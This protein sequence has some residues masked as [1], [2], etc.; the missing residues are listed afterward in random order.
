MLNNLQHMPSSNRILIYVL[1]MVV[2]IVA[3]SIICNNRGDAWEEKVR[4]VLY[5]LKNDSVPSYATEFIDEKGIPY[6]SYAPENGIAAGT[7]YNATIVANYALSYYEQY[8]KKNDTVALNRF[9]HC[10]Q[11]LLNEMQ[12]M[13]NA[14]LFIFNWQQP[15]YPAVKNPFTSGMTSGRAINAFMLA[16]KYSGDSIYLKQSQKLLRGYYIPIEKGGFTYITKNGWW[17]EEVADTNGQT[18]K[19]LDGHIYA[20]QGVQHLWQF[21][22][23]DS[24]QQVIQ[25]GI[26]ALIQALPLY[27]GDHGILYY[28][29]YQ[30]KAD[31]KYRK[32]LT[33][34]MQELWE[35]TNN[36]VFLN[37]Y[38]KWSKPLK[39]LYIKRIFAEKNISGIVLF[40]LVTSLL[41]GAIQLLMKL[42]SRRSS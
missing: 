8:Q 12:P 30:K 40:S 13:E 19:I 28:D 18:P 10:I 5:Q 25:R 37:Y 1:Q 15:W 11:W 32:I 6:V 26:D 3:A 34:Q 17:Y 41:F 29:V 21:T 27:D 23:D 14:A 36:P 35:T 31:K 7:K 22:K 38:N 33:Q 16:F 39:Q 9:N 4:T 2:A 24:A 20:I 42:F